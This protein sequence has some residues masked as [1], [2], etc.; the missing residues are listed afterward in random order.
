MHINCCHAYC[1]VLCADDA[2]LQS[3]QHRPQPTAQQFPSPPFPSIPSSHP[4]HQR[5]VAFITYGYDVLSVV[6]TLQHMHT[7]SFRLHALT[8]PTTLPHQRVVAFITYGYDV[9]NVVP[10]LQHMHDS[11]GGWPILLKFNPE[12]NISQR[13]H[14][15]EYRKAADLI[16]PYTLILSAAWTCMDHVWPS[17]TRMDMHAPCVTFLSTPLSPPPHHVQEAIDLYTFIDRM[18]MPKLLISASN[19]EFFRIDDS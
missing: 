15:K 18:D 7:P 6:P 11:L 8:S 2:R 1:M 4:P 16:D 13:L 10:T 12:Y 9:L 19:D 17:S 14:S 5:V 3:A